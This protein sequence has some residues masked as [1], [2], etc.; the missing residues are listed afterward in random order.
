[1]VSMHKVLLV[2]FVREY[3]RGPHQRP[4]RFMPVYCKTRGSF[5]LPLYYG[6]C[7]KYFIQGF[8]KLKAVWMANIFAKDYFIFFCF[9]QQRFLIITSPRFPD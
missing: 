1:M 8:K 9:R 3:G 7:I 6:A 5:G 2:W 4:V